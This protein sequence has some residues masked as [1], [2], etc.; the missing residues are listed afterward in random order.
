MFL[1]MLGFHLYVVDH[2]SI[3]KHSSTYLLNVEFE[4]AKRVLMRKESLEEIVQYQHGQVT[5]R[6][7]DR[8]NLSSERLLKG[9]EINAE[10][11]FVVQANNPQVGQLTL[12]FGQKAVI[13][14]TSINSTTYLISPCEYIKEIVTRTDMVPEGTQT[15]VTTESHLRYQRK[16]PK[17]WVEYMDAKVQEASV[18]MSDRSREAI[19]SLMDRN[20]NKKFFIPLVK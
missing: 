5:S 17:N 15:R 11:Q 2:S 3:G 13:T 7:W 19:T 1:I 12:H 10:G 18:T 6:Q 8:I 16:V 20:K 14:K 4:Q 9:W